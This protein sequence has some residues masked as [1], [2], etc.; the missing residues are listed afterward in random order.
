MI[1]F[2]SNDN[3]TLHTLDG[4]VVKKYLLKGSLYWLYFFQATKKESGKR[5]HC[6]NLKNLDP[7][8]SK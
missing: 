6:T 7:N 3:N 4:A 2:T 1:S 5:K 8:W